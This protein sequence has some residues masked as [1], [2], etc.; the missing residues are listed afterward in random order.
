MGHFC[1]KGTFAK[2]T[3]TNR[4]LHLFDRFCASQ[5]V[6]KIGRKVLLLLDAVSLWFDSLYPHCAMAGEPDSA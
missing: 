5:K 4:V 2:L 6:S 1:N 3:E